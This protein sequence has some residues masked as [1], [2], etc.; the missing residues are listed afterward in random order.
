MS[1]RDAGWIHTNRIRLD[2]LIEGVEGWYRNDQTWN[3]WAIIALPRHSAER[4]VALFSGDD[5]ANPDGTLMW[6]DGDTI[7]I[8]HLSYV[9]DEGYEDDRDEPI[10]VHG[11]QTWGPGSFSWVWSVDRDIVYCP[12]CAEEFD[13]EHD[14]GEPC[15]NCGGATLIYCGTCDR[16]GVK[17][18]S[19]L[20]AYE[21]HTHGE[22]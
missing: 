3:G 22:A 20:P 21:R 1:D 11:V 10:L 18:A 9:D 7:V 2:D 13:R 6:W 8:R 17:G 4:V 19:G 15:P 5:N 12:M 14:N 16:A